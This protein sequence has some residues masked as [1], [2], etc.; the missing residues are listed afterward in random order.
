[1]SAR[2]PLTDTGVVALGDTTVTGPVSTRPPLE[3]EPPVQSTG[4]LPW[5]L[6]QPEAS[7]RAKTTRRG[8]QEGA[9]ST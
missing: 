6:P 7:T 8:H 3:T 2:P 4:P 5:L 9:G 1:V